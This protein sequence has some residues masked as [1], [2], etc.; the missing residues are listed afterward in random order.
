MIE[1]NDDEV[2]ACNNMDAEQ[3]DYK[4][5]ITIPTGSYEI[6][7]TEK[8]ICTSLPNLSINI[9]ANNN[10]LISEIKCNQAINFVPKDSI[11]QLLGFT[12]RIL[13]PHKTHSSGLPVAILTINALRVESNITT[14]AYVNEHKNHTIY[15]FFPSVPPGL[16]IVEVSANIIYLPV[17]VQ[18]IYH[19]RLH[20]VD[21]DGRLVNFRRNTVILNIIP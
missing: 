3:L 20:I 1:K 15:E 10:E 6:T 19:L 21:Q 8:Y 5:V 12:N 14:G 9:K 2:L 16:M 18:A 17:V 4:K 7:G 13:E 11:G